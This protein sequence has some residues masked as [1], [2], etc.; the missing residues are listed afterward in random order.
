ME[1]EILI[2]RFK[3]NPILEP[4]D[5]SWINKYPKKERAAFNCGVIFD[6]KTRVYRMLFRGGAG[7]FSD[8]GLATSKDGI[9]WKVYPEPVLKHTDH[10]F[11]HGYCRRGIEDPRIV[12]W[13]DGYY[14]IFA[15]ACS[16]DHSETETVSHV[17]VWRT[18]NF[19][20]YQLVG[21]PLKWSDKDASIL[22]VPINN[23]A[24]LIYRQDPDVWISRSQDLT[25]K[26]DWQDH[27]ILLKSS[28][29][30]RSPI[31][32]VPANKIG[33]AGPPIRTPKGWL[34]IIHVVHK[35]RNEYNRAYSLG[36][37]VLDAKFPTKISYIHPA[38]I[39]WPEKPYETKGCVPVV[40]FSCATID[41]GGN[42]ILIYWG[43]ADTVICGGTLSKKEL[44]MCY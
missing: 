40:C 30:Y 42:D 33:I 1:K 5:V 36:F 20:K 4:K 2:R 43:G 9:K 13:I 31:S 14:Y 24:Y 19:L 8:L 15:T 16:R 23:W 21:I 6:K 17:G 44:P 37:I 10:N 22:P 27:Q 41:A 18:K 3:E 25:L 28:E 35:E 11:W 29:L 26:G 7:P 12:K 32:G 39:L 38:P 34:V